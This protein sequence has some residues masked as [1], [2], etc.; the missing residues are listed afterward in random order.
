MD[1]N[2]IKRIRAYFDQLI[3]ESSPTTPSWNMEKILLGKTNKWNYID[4]CMIKAIIE[5][6]HITDL[7]KYLSF[8]DEFIDFY[9]TDEGSIKTYSI[10]EYNIDQIN[11]GKVLFDLYELTG[12][13]KYRKA[14][15]TL[16]MQIKT[17][18]RTNE[19]NF[20][21]KNIYPH[22]VWLD[23]LYMGQPFY[24][25]YET[26]FNGFKK[27]KD[28]FTQF[29]NVE[30]NMKDSETGLYYHAY[31]SSKTMFWCNPKT[32]LSQNFW[33]RALGWFLMALIDVI[34]IMDEQMFFEYKYLMDMFKD[35]VDALI[36]VQSPSGMWYQ[37]VDKPETEGNYLETS[38]SAIM[39]YGILKGVRLDVLPERYKEY[40]LKAFDDIC[41]RYL[42]EDNGRLSLGGICLVAGLGGPNKRD[43]SVSYYLS[44]PIVKDDAKGVAPFLMCFNEIMREVGEDVK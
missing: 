37:V 13:E 4:G 41:N 26:K 30:K 7:E 33:G 16:Y 11:E 12:K 31:D 27:Y 25:A 36:N 35:L 44:E 28:I 29:I 32:G 10:D 3:K 34:E 1:K 20:W 15:D 40:G 18:P 22:Q 6:Y 8:A 39:A 38:A 43:G 2:R 42:S 24:M 5:L 17:H 14:I 23:G 9:V 19:G 21:H